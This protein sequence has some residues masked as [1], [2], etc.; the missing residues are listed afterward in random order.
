METVAKELLGAPQ[1]KVH[2]SV[3]EA[4]ELCAAALKRKGCSAEE[5]R[6][7]ADHVVDAALC[8]YEYSGPEKLLN[9][10]ADRRFAKPRKPISA[11]RETPVSAMYDGGNNVGMVAIYHATQAA[12]A[13]AQKN[14]VAIVGVTNCWMSGRIAYYLEMIAKADLIG[15]HFVGTTGSSVAPPG[16]AKAS[17]GTDPM[18]FGVPTAQGPFVFDMA[19][20]ATVFSEIALYQRNGKQLA[21]G[22]AIDKDGNPTCDPA[23]AMEGAILPFG[24][25]KGF[26]LGLVAHL[27]GVLAGCS[28]TS[29]NPHGAVFMVFKPDLI[30]PTDV[31]KTQAAQ[32]LAR[33]KATPR[34]PGVDEI[35][36]PSERASRSRARLTR[37]GIDIDKV[38]FDALSRA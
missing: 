19:I 21:E 23:R 37:D 4:H 31:F 17:L 6:I 11:I 16:A 38:I 28:M 9:V 20:S 34:Q 24:G 25:Y 33:V 26:G 27:F 10:M 13:K 35:R 7:L 30:A 15:L 29:E 5:A 22:A 3:S 18:A 8:G 36:L 32:F 12:I 2:L 14:G 1:G